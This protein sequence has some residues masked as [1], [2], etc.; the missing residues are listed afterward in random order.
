M[1]AA[2]GAFAL[3]VVPRGRSDI[4][5]DASVPMVGT[6]AGGGK[7]SASVGVV[8]DVTSGGMVSGHCSSVVFSVCASPQRWKRDKQTGNEKGTAMKMR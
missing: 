1:L 6:D 2:A 5:L 3:A 8:V 7:G 4:G